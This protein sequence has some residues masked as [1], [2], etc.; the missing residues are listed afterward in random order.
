MASGGEGHWSCCIPSQEAQR[1][2]QALPLLSPF[3]SG[4][5][6]AHGSATYLLGGSSTSVNPTPKLPLPT[7]LVS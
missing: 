3:Y 2:M 4:R 7:E 1:Q 5:P 6:S